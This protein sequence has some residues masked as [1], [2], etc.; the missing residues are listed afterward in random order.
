MQR[1]VTVF[2]RLVYSDVV[3][4]QHSRRF[5]SSLKRDAV[6]RGIAILLSDI[7][8]RSK[9]EE[10]LHDKML[11]CQRRSHERRLPGSGLTLIEFVAIEITA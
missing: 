1:R 5:R 4:N 2:V 8:I 7:R 9:L 11:A 3:L 6:G 10:S